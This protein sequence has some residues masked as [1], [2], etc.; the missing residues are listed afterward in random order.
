MN[1]RSKT[2]E[3][4][5]GNGDTGRDAK[6]KTPLRESELKTFGTSNNKLNGENGF[7]INGDYE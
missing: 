4:S 5:P 2:P 6:E 3:L 1:N 7:V